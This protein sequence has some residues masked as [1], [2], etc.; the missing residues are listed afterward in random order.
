MMTAR[1]AKPKLQSDDTTEESMYAIGDGSG[2]PE[3]PTG[4]QGGGAAFLK[5]LKRVAGFLIQVP[6]SID[7]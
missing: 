4:Q 5:S 7:L 6:K 1:R 2:A 3:T